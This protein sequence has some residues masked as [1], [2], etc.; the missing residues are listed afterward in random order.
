MTRS[1]TD[2]LVKRVYGL[3]QS[4]PIRI[5]IRL[6]VGHVISKSH[7][8]LG[9]PSVHVVSHRLPCRALNGNDLTRFEVGIAWDG[10]WTGTCRKIEQSGYSGKTA[11]CGGRKTRFRTRMSDCCESSPLEGGPW[12]EAKQ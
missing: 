7:L 2:P 12:R 11:A 6:K 1:S 3:D 8:I 4:V 9:R 5:L 10:P